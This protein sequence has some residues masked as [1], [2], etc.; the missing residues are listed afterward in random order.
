MAKFLLIHGGWQAAWCWRETISGLAAVNH[1]CIAIDLP[2]HG[3]DQAPPAAVTMEDYVDRIVGIVNESAEK[4]VLVGHSMG[5]VISQAAEA[6]PDRIRALVYVAALL[7]L[8]GS[9]MMDYLAQYDPAFIASFRFSHDGRTAEI[10]PEGA[11]EFLYG[12]C[13]AAVVDFALPR[14]TPE[15]VAPFDTSLKL[16]EARYGKVPRYYIETLRDRAIPLTLQRAMCSASPVKQVFSL[17][18]DHSPFLSMPGEFN[19]A[20]NQIGCEE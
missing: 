20:L 2:G 18:T 14:L 3:A 19:R 5:G 17:D 7:P 9:K 1:E 10:T 4:P 13:P 15:P 11:K 6:I 16:T 12:L 8:N